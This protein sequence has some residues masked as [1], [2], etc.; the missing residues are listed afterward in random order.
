MKKNSFN[1][2]YVLF[3]LLVPVVVIMYLF[4]RGKKG[5]VLDRQS[6][7]FQPD[8][9]VTPNGL[10]ERQ[11]KIVAYMRENNG[12]GRVS[13]MVKMFSETDRTLRRDL[14][15]LE[16]LGVVSRSGSTKSVS[17]SLSK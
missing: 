5:V 14:N 8:S 17:Y 4:K 11:L 12:F 1:P 9:E 7:D 13:D 16:G 6:Y 10:N 15:K 2:L 3:A